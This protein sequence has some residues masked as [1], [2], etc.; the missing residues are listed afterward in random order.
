MSFTFP[1]SKA[2]FWENFVCPNSLSNPSQLN[3]HSYECFA[4][5]KM[6]TRIMSLGVWGKKLIHI[7]ILILVFN[8]SE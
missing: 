6:T 7:K 8:D 2:M 4:N 3:K 1:K 5:T